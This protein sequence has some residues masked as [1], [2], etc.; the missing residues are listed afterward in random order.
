MFLNGEL[1]NG[2]RG[3]GSDVLVDIL[4]KIHPIKFILQYFH[5]FFYTKMSCFPTVM[6]LSDY[7]IML[8]WRNKEMVHLE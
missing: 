6:N 5:Y 1:E 4:L 7:I 2:A 3:V 8:S